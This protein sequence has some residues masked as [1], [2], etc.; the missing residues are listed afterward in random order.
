[1]NS[2]ASTLITYNPVTVSAGDSL[3]QVLRL[4]EEC[5]THHIPV[6]DDDFHLLGIISDL[7]VARCLEASGGDDRNAK[8]EI[9]SSYEDSLLQREPFDESL[10]TAGDMMTRTV[11]AL[12]SDLAPLVALQSLLAKRFHSIP[13][14]CDGRLA[15]IV[16]SSDFL[17]EFAVL[18]PTTARTPIAQAMSPWRPT[19]GIEAGC[20]A[21]RQMMAAHH[22]D[23]LGV[24]EGVRPR[25]VLSQRRLR[26]ANRLEVIAD[27]SFAGDDLLLMNDVASIGDLMSAEP[28]SIPA[29]R[30]L[31]EAAA[32]LYERKLDGLAVVDAAGQVKGMITETDLLRALSRSLARHA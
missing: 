28:E 12:E 29:L 5:E 21:A 6:V 17:R 4:M 14:T 18:A 9:R 23:F 15:G 8:P 2:A 26:R 10:P 22:V 11:T 25:G 24:A 1:M 27:G 20:L 16:T 30:S 31:G 32:V 13:I 3:A 7:D 19:I